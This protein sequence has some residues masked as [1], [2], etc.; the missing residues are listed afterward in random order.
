V[1]V[2][3]EAL[4]GEPNAGW[5]IVNQLLQHERRAMG[6]GSDHFF[7]GVSSPSGAGESVGVE[8]A[9]LARRHGRADDPVA[10][11]LVAEQHALSRVG[12]QLNARVATGLRSGR[13]PAVSPSLLKLFTATSSVRRSDVT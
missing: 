12:A 9:G 8:L 1:V 10:R 11:Q 3:R 6:G 5:G 2:P 7:R 13:M 4:L